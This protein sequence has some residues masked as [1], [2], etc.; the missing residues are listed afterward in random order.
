[1]KRERKPTRRRRRAGAICLFIVLT[2]AAALYSARPSKPRSVR[3]S[4]DYWASRYDVNVHL[5]RAV[6]W[7]ES[8]DNPGVISSTGARGVMQVEPGTWRYTEKLI[9]HPVA[10]TSDGNVQIGVAYLRHLL[11]EFHGNRHLAVAAYYQGPEA[12]RR[13]GV[14]RSSERYVANVLA[15]SRRL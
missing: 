12:V 1:M 7:V 9:G 15:L 5:V 2:L 4:I 8:G 3:A 14:Y 10:P 11:R 13:L 6:A